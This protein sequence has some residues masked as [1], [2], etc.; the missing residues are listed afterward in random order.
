MLSKKAISRLTKLI[1]FMESLPASANKHF[2]MQ[3]FI[4]HTGPHEHE[5]NVAKPTMKDLHTC[6][7]AACALGWAVTN[8]TFRRWGLRLSDRLFVEGAIEA[9]DLSSA[10][11]EDEIWSEDDLWSELFDGTNAD[12]TQKQWAKRARKVLRRWS[13]APQ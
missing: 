9:F 2:D 12:R 4:S 11:T 3:D 13:K 8:P 7:T 5:I 6:G 10:N 1:E